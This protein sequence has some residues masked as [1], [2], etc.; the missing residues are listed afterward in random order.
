[1]SAVEVIAKV[2]RSRLLIEE[3]T[4]LPLRGASDDQIESEQRIIGRRF[5]LGLARFLR[6]WN[7]ANLDVLVLFGCGETHSEIPRFRDRQSL[8]PKQM[9]EATIIGSDPAGFVFAESSDGKVISID[10][11]DGARKVVGSS[12]DDF[13]CRFVFGLDSHLFAGDEWK[14]ELQDVGLLD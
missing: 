7:G 2:L 12:F 8:R 5:S 6:R 11:Q 14:Q 13:I 4:V 3:L 9:E 1:M 10:T